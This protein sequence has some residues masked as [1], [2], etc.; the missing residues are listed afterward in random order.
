MGWKEGKPRAVVVVARLDS[1]SNL[2]KD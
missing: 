1:A 2:V